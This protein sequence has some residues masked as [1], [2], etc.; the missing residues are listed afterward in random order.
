ML[1]STGGGLRKVHSFSVGLHTTSFQ[2]E[3]YAIK[4]CTME[5][6]EYSVTGRN[7]DILSNCQATI[8]DLHSLQVHSKL[9]CD[10]HQCQVTLSEHTKNQQVWVPGHE[11]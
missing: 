2:A 11:N 6:V 3:I 4:A 10:C 1:G 8:T 5:N 7:S 9:A